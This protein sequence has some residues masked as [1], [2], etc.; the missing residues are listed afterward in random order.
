VVGGIIL[1]CQ[2]GAEDEVLERVGVAHKEVFANA[3]LIILLL[4][5]HGPLGKS[6]NTVIG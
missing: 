3:V 4:V 1:T 6:E 2:V 5:I